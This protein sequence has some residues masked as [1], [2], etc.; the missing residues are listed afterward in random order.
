MVQRIQRFAQHNV[1]KRT[2]LQLIAEE[3]LALQPGAGDAD[4]APG[5]SL[6]S[7][8][9]VVGTP[10]SCNLAYLLHQL[11]FDGTDVTLESASQVRTLQMSSAPLRNCNAS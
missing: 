8:S 7:A 2:A 9:N 5:C 11:H 4:E 6:D 1:F 10:H 3:L